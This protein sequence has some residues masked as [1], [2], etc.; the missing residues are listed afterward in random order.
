[1]V[2]FSDLHID[3][4]YTPGNSNTCGH[5]TCCRKDSGRGLTPETSAGKWGD[6]QCD[7]PEYTARNM[8]RFIREHIKPDAALWPGDS[9][10]HHLDSLSLELNVKEMIKV[11]QIVKEEIRDIPMWAAVGNH[12]TYP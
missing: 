11:S 3:F 7:I 4:D 6:Y 10:G 2:L 12:D 8:L 9:I 1:M 5:V